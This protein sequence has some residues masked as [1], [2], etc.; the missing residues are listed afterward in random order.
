MRR[1]LTL[2]AAIGVLVLSQLVGVAAAQDEVPLRA[3]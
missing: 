2:L 1:V 3:A